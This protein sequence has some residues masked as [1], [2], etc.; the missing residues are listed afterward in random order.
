M[1][2]KIGHLLW[3]S[4]L[5]FLYSVLSAYD[6]P[7]LRLCDSLRPDQI[8]ALMFIGEAASELPFTLFILRQW[9]ISKPKEWIAF[10]VL[11]VFLAGW[12]VAGAYCAQH[13]HLGENRMKYSAFSG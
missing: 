8:L 6:Q 4:T 7:L 2:D 1:D 5:F 9:S 13:L 11:G 12:H 10:S 3:G